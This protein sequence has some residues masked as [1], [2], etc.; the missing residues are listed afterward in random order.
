MHRSGFSVLF[1][2]CFA[3]P[4]GALAQA[5]PNKP[6]LL[7]SGASVGSG[8][9]VAM[10]TITSRMGEALGQPI[11][12][13]ARRGAGGLEA[14]AAGARAEANGYTLT[15]A[16][17][18]LV[19]NRFMKKDMPVDAV[20]DYTPIVQIFNVAFFLAA[21]ASVPAG[22]LKELIEYSKRNPGKLDYASTG[23]G[24]VAHLVGE[25]LNMQAGMGILHVPYS[26]NNT[27]MVVNDLIT[28]RIQLYLA[29]LPSFV[30]H[31]ASGKIKLIAYFDRERSRLRPDVQTVN[32]TLPGYYN[33]VVWYG[34]LG[35]AGMPRAITERL[36]IEANKVTGD[37]ALAP[38]FDA[39]G[40][41]P[42]T[43]RSSEDF[44]RQIASD[45]ENIGRIVKALG[46]KPE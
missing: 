29:A 27:S 33:I 31:V 40:V 24:S 45:V 46:L 23:V 25:S 35:P 42:L 3:V 1:A 16:N 30:Q 34:F 5:Y 43:G 11:V 8:G 37:P 4:P 39:L 38:R 44:A 13:E 36:R 6:I 18:G 2:V 41:S 20:K 14:Y 15:F 17:G 21:H 28:G 32:E 9:D 22:S 7:L 12:V 10:R 19:T 26:G